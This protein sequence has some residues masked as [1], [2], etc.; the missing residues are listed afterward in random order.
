VAEAD[1]VWVTDI[2]GK[3][4]MDMLAAYSAIN[5]GHRHPDLID[6]AKE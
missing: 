4:Y 2:D 1:G 6:A 3:R 5:F